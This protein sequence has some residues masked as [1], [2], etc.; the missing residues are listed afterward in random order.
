MIPGL[1]HYHAKTVALCTTWR[2]EIFSVMDTISYELV[3]ALQV[4]YN[5]AEGGGCLLLMILMLQFV[6]FC[7]IA[8]HS[9]TFIL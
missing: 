7:P 4:N 8:A 3:T 9:A 6:C 1:A 2:R 5:W